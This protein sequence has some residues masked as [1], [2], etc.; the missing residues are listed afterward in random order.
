[1]ISAGC[2]VHQ[3]SESLSIDT[4]ATGLIM[5]QASMVIV[6]NDS[7]ALPLAIVNEAQTA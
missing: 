3:R 6:H 5:R 4:T 7:F 1:M 2:E